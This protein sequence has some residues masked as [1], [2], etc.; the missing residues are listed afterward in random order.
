MGSV[1]G[2]LVYGS[3]GPTFFFAAAGGVAIA[4][5]LASWFVLAG[6][7][8]ERLA[9]PGSIPFEMGEPSGGTRGGAVESSEDD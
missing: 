5:G 8:G 6:P 4:G 1:I 3:A 7:V 2:G 9:A